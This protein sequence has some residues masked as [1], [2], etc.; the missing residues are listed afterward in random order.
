MDLRF[1]GQQW[2]FPTRGNFRVKLPRATAH[3]V[4]KMLDTLSTNSL[5]TKIPSV[6]VM[7]KEMNR[8]VSINYTF[9][10]N[11]VDHVIAQ[12]IKDVPDPTERSP[13]PNT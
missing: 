3:K 2:K 5:S 13:V 12:A 8:N 4:D 11:L 6:H 9:Q 1:H 7:A 10:S